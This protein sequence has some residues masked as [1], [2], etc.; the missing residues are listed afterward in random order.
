MYEELLRDYNLLNKKN[1]VLENQVE[2]LKIELSH[3]IHQKLLL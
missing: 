1:E 2:D 3:V